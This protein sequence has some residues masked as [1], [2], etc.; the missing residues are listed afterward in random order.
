MLLRILASRTN[1]V[2]VL[3]A[4]TF[5]LVTTFWLLRYVP[6]NE[7]WLYTALF[8][9]PRLPLLLPP[10]VL[11]IDSILRKDI[12]P[13]AVN[14]ASL[15]VVAGP[16]MGL[17]VGGLLSS[18]AEANA[19]PPIRVLTSNI[20]G[21][22]SRPYNLLHE[23]RRSRPDIILLQE[24]TPQS[25]ELLEQELADW[26]GVSSGEFWVAARE[27]PRIV[28]EC[29]TR[30]FG[31]TTALACETSVNG[32]PVTVVSVHLTTV[33]WGLEKLL[34]QAPL[35]GATS[36]VDAFVDFES[37]R[38]EEA[39]ATRE[40][41]RTLKGPLILGGDFNA[42]PQLRLYS[43][44]WSGLANAFTDAGLG[45]GYTARCDDP[46]FWPANTPWVRIDH[47]L[48]SAD[49]RCMN[50]GRGRTAGSDHR[51]VWADLVPST[52]AR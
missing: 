35:E 22:Q 19:A 48:S 14:I 10:A 21:G 13:V 51:L 42:T 18:Q 33:R 16:L 24:V 39:R 5:L 36:R 43:A 7:W 29:Q 9:F 1:V 3:T 23:I 44:H 26:R 12:A 11:L 45:Y 34:G 28:G 46:A 15:A 41:T 17:S 31:R 50:V 6:G 52:N 2:R 32:E 4:V 38:F 27:R 47:L 40:W 37:L 8:Y 20:Q 30:P 25:L 49:W